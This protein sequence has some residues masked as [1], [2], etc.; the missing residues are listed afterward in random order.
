MAVWYYSGLPPAPI[1]WVLTRDPAGKLRAQ[2]FLATD[3]E[4]TLAEI[5]GWFVSRWRVETTLQEVRAHL[6][7]ETQRQWSDLAH[8]SGAARAVLPGDDLD[9]WIDRNPWRRHPDTSG[10]LVF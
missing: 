1:R 5:L 8:H 7:V 9:A 6:G 10:N 2:A 3:I 4:T